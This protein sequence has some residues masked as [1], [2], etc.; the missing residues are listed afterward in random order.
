[1]P[2]DLYNLNSNYGTE[3]EL[4]ECVAKMHAAGLGAVADIVINHRCAQFQDGNG[5]WNQYGGKMAWDQRAIV[6]NDPNFN[7]HGNHATGDIFAAAP[8]IDHQQEFVRNDIK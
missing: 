1:M 8:N 3:D 2:G 4:R 7:G 6:G 5:V